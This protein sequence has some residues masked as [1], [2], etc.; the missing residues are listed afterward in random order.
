MN[1]VLF[2]VNLVDGS[3]ARY[4]TAHGAGSVLTN[5]G[6]ARKFSNENNSAKSSLGFARTAEIYEG[7]QKR[8]LKLD[9]LSPTDSNLR[10]RGIIVHG[11]DQVKEA[12]VVQGVGAGCIML[13]WKIRDEV[14]DKIHGGSL[15]MMGFSKAR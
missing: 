8:S 13:D 2:I 15:M 12:N 1:T 4:H 3:V 6:Y 9:G 10:M 11:A 14:I 7:S 5:P